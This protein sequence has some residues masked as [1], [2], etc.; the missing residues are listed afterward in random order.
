M[1]E[2]Q[3]CKA[4]CDSESCIEA[5]WKSI[6]P[7]LT[8]YMANYYSFENRVYKGHTKQL[9]TRGKPYINDLDQTVYCSC[10]AVPIMPIIINGKEFPPP[11]PPRPM[12]HT[13]S[14]WTIRNI[15]C[16]KQ[17]IHFFKCIKQFIALT[18]S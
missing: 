11:L 16:K 4:N 9:H 6:Q 10:N 5:R 2:T 14:T 15:L 12:R 18:P 3:Q 13:I 7:H 1:T 8:S 17:I